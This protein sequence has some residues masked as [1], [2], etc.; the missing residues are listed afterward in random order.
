MSLREVREIGH[1]RPWE[2]VGK[3]WSDAATS[4]GTSGVTRNWKRPRI[5]PPLNLGPAETSILDFWPP[6]LGG[7]ILVFYFK[8]VGRLMK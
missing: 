4:Q 5:L 1:R 2:G 6:E 3:A 8:G 7:Y